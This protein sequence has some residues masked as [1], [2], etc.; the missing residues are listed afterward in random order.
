MKENFFLLKV[1][2]K[3]FNSGIAMEEKKWKVFT[4]NVTIS[5]NATN[6]VACHLTQHSH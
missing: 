6:S 4:L 2:L 5:C 3:P 1:T